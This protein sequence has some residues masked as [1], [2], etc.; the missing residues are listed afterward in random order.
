[1]KPTKRFDQQKVVRYVQSGSVIDLKHYIMEFEKKCINFTLDFRTK[2]KHKRT[3]MHIAC[4]FGDEA[5]VKCLIKYGAR[6]DIKDFTGNLPMHLAAQFVLE[7][8]EFYKTHKDIM[9]PLIKHHPEGVYVK[10]HKGKTPGDYLDEAREK[11]HKYCEELAEKNKEKESE[12]EEGGEEGVDEEKEEGDKEKKEDNE[13]Q[14]ASAGTKRPVEENTSEIDDED[15]SPFDEKEKDN[16][17]KFSQWAERM[18]KEYTRRQRFDGLKHQKSTK[19]QKF[20]E[21]NS[22]QFTEEKA[23]KTMKVFKKKQ[24]LKLQKRVEDYQ[25]S[26]KQMRELRSGKKKIKFMDIPWPCKRGTTKEQ[27]EVIM[28]GLEEG[29]DE[30]ARLK[31]IKRQLLMWHSD[32]LKQNFGGLFHEDHKEMILETVNSISQELTKIK[33]S[34]GNDFF[35]F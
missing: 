9:D 20:N 25:E 24:E 8:G 26:L 15:E 11:Y 22:M 1:M 28:K 17:K 5:V 7:N 14:S 3:C 13:E 12:D 32:K 23:N 4:T 35:T 10:N 19:R 30:K 2:G 16:V 34:D 18:S 31:Y 27:V 29:A 6:T 21:K 33:D